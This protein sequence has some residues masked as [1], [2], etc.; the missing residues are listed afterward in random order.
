MGMGRKS[1]Y[2]EH[3]VRPQVVTVPKESPNRFKL[4]KRTKKNKETN[5]D[6]FSAKGPWVTRRPRPRPRPRPHSL[7]GNLW[8]GA[9]PAWMRFQGLHV[10]TLT[11]KPPTNALSRYLVSTSLIH[12]SPIPCPTL[13]S[14][15]FSRKMGYSD[16]WMMP[17]LVG[18]APW[19]QAKKV[20]RRPPCSVPTH[21]NTLLNITKSTVITFP[22][23]FV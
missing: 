19:A 13:S 2:S 5:L 15:L 16:E 17:W 20:F 23:C 8:I 4:T 10:P 21:S 7:Q 22:S 12:P 9:A 18:S 3:P 14:W 6:V 1:R 11:T